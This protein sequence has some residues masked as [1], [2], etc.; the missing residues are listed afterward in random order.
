ML[1][2]EKSTGMQQSEKH[3]YYLSQMYVD[4][5]DDGTLKKSSLCLVPWQKDSLYICHTQGGLQEYLTE[6][7]GY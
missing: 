7:K 5:F 6:L 2:T 4:Y 1:P 3:L